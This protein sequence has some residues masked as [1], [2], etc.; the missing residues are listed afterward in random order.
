MTNQSARE[1]LMG[2]E[3]LSDAMVASLRSRLAQQ[4]RD[5]SS[6]DGELRARLAAKDAATTNTFVAGT[7]GAMAAEADDEVI[8][9]LRHEQTELVAAQAALDRIDQGEYGACAECGEAIGTHR[10]SVLPSAHLCVHCQDLLEHRQG[11]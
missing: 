11:R 10:L 7:E 3:D 1:C 6:K 2:D 4:V 5:L 8:A 9:L